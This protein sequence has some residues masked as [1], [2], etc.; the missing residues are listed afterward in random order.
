MAKMSNPQMNLILAAHNR[1]A[2]VTPYGS[3]GEVVISSRLFASGEALRRN[4]WAMQG[5]HGWLNVTTAGLIAA[6]VDIEAL[7]AE[8]ATENALRF[9]GAAL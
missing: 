7:H 6:G 2:K 9:S 8:A 1:P 4:G 3:R 5:D